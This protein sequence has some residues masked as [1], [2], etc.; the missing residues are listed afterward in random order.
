V[1]NSKSH[2]T[3]L[4]RSE[5]KSRPYQGGEKSDS[6]SKGL[7][8][9]KRTESRGILRGNHQGDPTFSDTHEKRLMFLS[10]LFRENQFTRR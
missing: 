9:W 2:E 3:L 10:H 6:W 4:G 5:A 1:D 8:F 7:L